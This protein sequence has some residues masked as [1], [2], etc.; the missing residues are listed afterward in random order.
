MNAAY[1]HISLVHLPIILCPLGAIL[2][3]TA[4]MRDS[5]HIARVAL[6]L[7]LAASVIVI[8]VFLLG[9]PAEEIV[10]HIAG[11]SEHT[12]EEH[13]EAAE[14]ALWLTISSGISALI[15]WFCMIRG[16][17][18]ER[19]ALTFTFL[20]STISGIALAYTAHQGGAIRHPEAF[21]SSSQ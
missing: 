16:A 15:S 13:E 3:A 2:L 20:L 9:E 10:E 6:A 21:S 5:A 1:L 17:A 19:I 8:P 4:H 18:L 12:I 14:I 7:I 11:I